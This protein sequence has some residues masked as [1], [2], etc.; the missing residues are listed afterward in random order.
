[1]IDLIQVVFFI[2]IILCIR[3]YSGLRDEKEERLL[4]KL[5][6][7]IKEELKQ[8]DEKVIYDS[9]EC[10]LKCLHYIIRGQLSDKELQDALIRY[11]ESTVKEVNEV[12]K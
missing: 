4:K 7:E 10:I 9:L 1:M 5:A 2:M 12:Q 3:C 6:K 8:D 11:I